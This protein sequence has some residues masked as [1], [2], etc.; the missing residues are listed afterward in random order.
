MS[1]SFNMSLAIDKAGIRKLCFTL[2]NALESDNIHVTTVTVCGTIQPG[3]LFDPDK[4]AEVY[5]QLHTQS[6]PDWQR[7]FGSLPPLQ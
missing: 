1:L 2:A 7:E 3:T 5:W 4:I 6:K